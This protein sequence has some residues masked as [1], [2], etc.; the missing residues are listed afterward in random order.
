MGLADVIARFGTGSYQ[1]T[2]PAIGTWV[3][4]H[5]VNEG[6]PSTFPI[7]ASVQPDGVDLRDVPEG[8]RAEDVR[9]LWTKVELRTASTQIGASS[10]N[11][12]GE[13][14]VISIDGTD[15]R[16]FRVKHHTILDD[17]YHVWVA[18]LGAP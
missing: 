10:E 12:S 1:V 13:P 14:D 18:K 7:D 16:V 15:Y 2:R 8:M 17:F 11:E 9:E 6:A 4:G 3:D 5:Y